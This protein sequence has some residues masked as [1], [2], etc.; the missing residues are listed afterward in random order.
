[1]RTSVFALTAT[2]GLF[3]VIAAAVAAVALVLSPPSGEIGP[4]TT[5]TVA[6]SQQ[7]IDEEEED[8]ERVA[9]GTAWSLHLDEATRQS[10][11]DAARRTGA[12]TAVRAVASGTAYYGAV[13]GQT[14]AQDDFYAIVMTNQIHFWSKHGGNAWRYRGDFQTAG[15]IPPLPSQL[16]L[17]WGLSLSTERPAD[18]PPCPHRP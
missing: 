5:P 16:Y 11:V 4:A 15:C 14:E 2:A 17:A 6:T 8:G 3:I 10:L 12:P 18:L 7:A 13:Y 1:M 9:P